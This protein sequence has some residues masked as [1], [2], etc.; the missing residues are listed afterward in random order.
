[1]T[2][3]VVYKSH[4]S[5]PNRI[6]QTNYYS[7]SVNH[8]ALWKLTE[9]SF[10]L[11]TWHKVCLQRGAPF[12]DITRTNKTNADWEKVTC[13][14]WRQIKS[15]IFTRCVHL[16]LSEIVETKWKEQISSRVGDNIKLTLALTVNSI[17][18]VKNAGPFF[19]L[20]SIVGEIVT[21]LRWYS[22]SYEAIA[23]A[24]LQVWMITAIFTRNMFNV[25]RGHAQDENCVLSIQSHSE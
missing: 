6:I 20:D 13:N 3:G 8:T 19:S 23:K 14:R 16:P 1:M 18:Y 12:H 4:T 24:T 17:H 10:N 11:I 7:C 2:L 22:P 9:L 21:R 5:Q 15:L 25:L